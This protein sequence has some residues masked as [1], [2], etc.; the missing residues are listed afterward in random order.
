MTGFIVQNLFQIISVIF[1]A[2]CSTQPSPIFI[3]PFHS[4]CVYWEV[5]ITLMYYS[6][7]EGLGWLCEVTGYNLK[8]RRKEAWPV[9]ECSL[10]SM[11]KWNHPFC[12]LP[13]IYQWDCP[14][15]D[16]IGGG[17][18]LSPWALKRHHDGDGKLHNDWS[19]LQTRP[20]AIL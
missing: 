12:V 17:K 14:N 8:G 18:G 2:D 15:G 4:L 9:L 5:L 3:S 1:K 7:S 13:G 6:L 10:K 16:V 11:L 19:Y 20:L